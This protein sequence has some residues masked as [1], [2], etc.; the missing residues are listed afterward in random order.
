MNS[1]DWAPDG[2]KLVSGSDDRS[3]KVWDAT[4]YQLV[5]TLNGHTMPVRTVAWSPDGNR[6]ASGSNDGTIKVWDAQT[7]NLLTSFTVGNV[8]W[9]VKW[10]PDGKTILSGDQANLVKLWNAQTYQLIMNFSGHT[11]RVYSVTW[12][13]IG[14]RAVTNAD[15]VFMNQ[16]VPNIPFSVDVSA[17]VWYPTNLSTGVYPL[18]LLLH[19]NHGICRLPGS[20]DDVCSS[21]PPNCP[22][23][24]D[25]TPNHRG[26]DYMASKLASWGYLVAS[27]DANAINCRPGTLITERGRLTQEHLRR[28][29][30]WNSPGGAPPFGTLFSG[31]V[32]LNN[33]GL[34]GHSRGGE[35]MRA[36][37]TFNRAEGAPFGINALFEVAPTDFAMPQYTAGDIAS[38]VILPGCDGDVQD[39][40]GMR[41]FDRAQMLQELIFPSSKAQQFIW[42]GNHNFFNSEWAQNDTE[43]CTSY[44]TCRC[45]GQTPITRA[46][47]ETSGC[48]YVSSFFRLFLGGEGFQYLFTRGA[49]P[50]SLLGTPIDNAYAESRNNVRLVD[51]FSDPASPSINSLGGP[52]LWNGLTVSS[53]HDTSGCSSFDPV[54]PDASTVWLHD[55]DEHAAKIGWLAANGSLSLAFPPQQIAGYSFLSFRVAEQNDPSNPQPPTSQDFSIQLRDSSGATSAPASIADLFAPTG[56]VVHFPVGSTNPCLD[57]PSCTMLITNERKSILETVRFPLSFFTGVNLTQI[58]E[59]DFIFSRVP[60]GA[61]FMGDIHFE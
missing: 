11:D 54:N 60:A 30:Q 19:G 21:L 15:Y 23:G 41:A 48:M 52:N 28:W 1:V 2:T 13:S 7:Y 38:S 56:L 50:P 20:T 40:S 57:P 5:A 45:T 35:G 53:C 31:R 18:V 14:P 16:T 46:M 26:Y 42:G 36:A 34:M 25:R 9:S 59:I 3:L 37:Q 44:P 47:E 4:T 17:T 58:T 32:N 49:P 24:Y 10:S 39:N 55:P 12:T 51:D 8:V 22:D 27:I 33:I 43:M 6:I 29:Q 61:I